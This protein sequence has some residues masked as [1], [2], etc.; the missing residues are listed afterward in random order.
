MLA[1]LVFLSEPALRVPWLRVTDPVADR[2]VLA[3][4]SSKMRTAV[5][6][7]SA[8][9]SAEATTRAAWAVAMV[10]SVSVSSAAARA[11]S[12]VSEVAVAAISFET[13]DLVDDF[14]TGAVD[15]GAAATPGCGERGDSISCRRGERIRL[16]M[17]RDIGES[18]LVRGD[19][20]VSPTGGGVA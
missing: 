7:A 1:G 18:P 16:F 14:L 6:L 10:A 19:C 11:V 15:V 20:D 8:A 13:S 9:T 5:E 4:V 2:L 12:T 3:V 17:Y